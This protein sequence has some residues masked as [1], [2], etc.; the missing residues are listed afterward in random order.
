MKE[1]YNELNELLTSLF[2]QLPFPMGGSDD[3]MLSIYMSERENLRMTAIV[4][5]KGYTLVSASGEILQCS[6]LQEVESAFLIYFRN[7][8]GSGCQLAKALGLE[9]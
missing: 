1:R 2:R 5:E 8:L 6:T 4:T 3:K 7:R 9:V